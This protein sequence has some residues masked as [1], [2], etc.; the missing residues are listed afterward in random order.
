MSNV[1]GVVNLSFVQPVRDCDI[2]TIN[3]D[4]TLNNIPASSEVT[5]R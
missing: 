1:N 5:W 2:E 3:G 4:V